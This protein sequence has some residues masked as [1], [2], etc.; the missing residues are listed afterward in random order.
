MPAWVSLGK[1]RAVWSQVGNDIPLYIT[2]PTA[3][4]SAGGEVQMPDAAPFE[5]LEIRK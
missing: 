1:I 5:E 2:C 3:S 4:I